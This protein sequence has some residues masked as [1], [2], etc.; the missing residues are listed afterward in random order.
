MD[1]ATVREYPQLCGEVLSVAELQPGG[2]DRCRPDPDAEQHE[3][4]DRVSDERP[5]TPPRTPSRWFATEQLGSTGRTRSATQRASLSKGNRP[6]KAH[7]AHRSARE[8]TRGGGKPAASSRSPS[9]RDIPTRQRRPFS[10]TEVDRRADFARW[11]RHRRVNSQRVSQAWA[12]DPCGALVAL[13]CGVP[14]SLGLTWVALDRSDRPGLLRAGRRST[15]IL[16]RNSP[17]E[18]HS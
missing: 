9:A 6:K 5:T 10:R 14:Q 4:T 13:G 2:F 12:I 17:R 15:G 16:R 8:P 18:R 11:K 7:A 3:A 1:P